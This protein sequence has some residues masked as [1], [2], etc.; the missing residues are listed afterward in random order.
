MCL[1]QVQQKIG[2]LGWALLGGRT[3]LEQTVI[4]AVRI[5]R[6]SANDT[7]HFAAAFCGFFLFFGPLAGSGCLF[8]FLLE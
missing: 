7:E 2:I 3:G 8:C 5:F 6:D 1:Q 4:F